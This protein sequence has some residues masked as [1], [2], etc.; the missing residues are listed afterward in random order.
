MAKDKTAPPG[1]LH[2]GDRPP[3]DLFSAMKQ[4]SIPTK[5][6]TRGLRATMRQ[7]KDQESYPDRVPSP[8]ARMKQ[9]SR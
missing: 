9:G 2:K 3:Q 6:P 1:A 5:E 8:N 7:G 4:G